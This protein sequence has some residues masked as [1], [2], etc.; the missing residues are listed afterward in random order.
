MRS[1]IK[2][3]EFLTKFPKAPAAFALVFSSLSYKRSIKSGTQGLRCSY[4]LLLWN[5]A[6][7]TAKQANFLTFLSLALQH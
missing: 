5:P 3:F 1:G 7:P 6:F 4:N 2:V